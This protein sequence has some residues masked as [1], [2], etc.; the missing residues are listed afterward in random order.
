[1]KKELEIETEK[2]K[3][4]NEVID[5]RNKLKLAEPDLQL[6]KNSINCLEKIE[7]STKINP[8]ASPPIQNHQL[9]H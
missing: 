3:A 4:L 2:E 1:M 8:V 6:G 9:R 7:Y 5:A